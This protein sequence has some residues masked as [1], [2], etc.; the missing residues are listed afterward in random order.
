MTFENYTMYS[1]KTSHMNMCLY[2][3]EITKLHKDGNVTRYILSKTWDYDT[4]HCQT[5]Q[6]AGYV[7]SKTRVQYLTTITQMKEITI[8]HIQLHVI[9][10]PYQ[11]VCLY[12]LSKHCMNK[13]MICNTTP[14]QAQYILYISIRKILC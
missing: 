13:T 6:Q 12:I 7:Y 1:T 10:Q 5:N 11:E 9:L 14:S 4:T 3:R 2:L 8:N